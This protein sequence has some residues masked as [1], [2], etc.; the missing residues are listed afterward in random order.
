[1]IR[2]VERKEPNWEQYATDR[3]IEHQ[4][5]LTRRLNAGWNEWLADLKKQAKVIDNRHVFF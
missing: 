5:L 1:M 2:L 4:R 3:E